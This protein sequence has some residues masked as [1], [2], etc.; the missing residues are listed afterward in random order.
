MPKKNNRDFFA[1]SMKGPQADEVYLWNAVLQWQP[2]LI[3]ACPL[4][5]LAKRRRASLLKGMSSDQSNEIEP[6][7]P[8]Q[9]NSLH[10]AANH[11]VKVISL[12]DG[13]GASNWHV[14]QFIREVVNLNW[15]VDKA[16]KVEE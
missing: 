16:L 4:P 10:L 14:S 9:M 8:E 2:S 7:T 3:L 15:M 13:L 5:I 1:E 6:A 11:A 12:A